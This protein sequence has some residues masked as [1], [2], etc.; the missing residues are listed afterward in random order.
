MQMQD[1][2]VIVIGAGVGGLTAAALLAR[3]GRR[4]LCLERHEMPGGCAGWFHE[5]GYNLAVG[6]TLATGLEPGGLHD[7]IYRELGEP[8]PRHVP[9]RTAMDLHLPLPEG[10]RARRVAVHTDRGA[11][12]A[13]RARAFGDAHDAFWAELQRLAEAGYR[14]AASRAVLPL[15][16]ARDLLDDARAALSPGGPG[17]LGALAVLRAGQETLGQALA[18]HGA[19]D[20]L[21]R[22]CLEAQVVDAA[23]SHA[24]ACPLAQ[25]ALALEIYRFGCQHVFGGLG[26][27]A[28]DL[29]RALRRAGGK[30]KVRCAAE[31]L[32]VER[33]RVCGVVAGGRELRARQVI[34]A[35]P[36]ELVAPWLP[37]ELGGRLAP[38]LRTRRAPAGADT[39]EAGELH[40]WGAF[41]LYLGI[42]AEAAAHLPPDRLHHLVVGD[43]GQPMDEG[44]SVF[45]SLSHPEDRHRAPPGRR[46]L[47]ISTHTR[48]APWWALGEAA[49]LRRRATY[50]E[51][52]LD[53][54]EVALPGLR[55]GLDLCLPGTP[56]TF[57]RFTGRPEGRV[58]GTPQTLRSANLRAPGHRGEIPGL[59][60][61]GDAVW[62]GQGVVGVS[63]SAAHLARSVDRALAG[64]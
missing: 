30:L 15:R 8:L 36:P 62:P 43:L 58:G 23:Q 32:L 31:G 24:D 27:I 28:R 53:A 17:P 4:V 59:W 1:P 41:T 26:Q 39:G 49:Y 63:L 19:A 55:R 7:Q 20:P 14:L 38:R 2:D 12:R 48:V 57:A 60:F 64:A 50:S 61:G 22:A 42:A 18:R 33:G 45:L 25:A 3:R 13:E 16:S 5:R 29:T 46:A 34:A 47:T 6:A 35:V 9:L 51:R 11:W 21:H 37:A 44:N 10:H 56:R 52:L 54:A 40:E